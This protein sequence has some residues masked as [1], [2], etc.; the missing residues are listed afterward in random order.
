[1][2]RMANELYSGGEYLARN[3]TWHVEDSAWKAQQIL[4]MLQRH[5]L[6]PRTICE[7][8]CGAGEVLRQLQ[9]RMDP[10]CE[11]CGYD[12][13]PQAIALCRERANDR[14]RFHCRDFLQE[15]GA[16]FDLLLLIDLIEHL[17]DYN[18]FLR[19]VKPRSRYTILHIPLDLSVQ[20]K[21]RP[22]KLR[23]IRQVA[24]H[25][26]YF[27][28]ATALDG[29]RDAGYEIVDSFLTRGA[30]ESTHKQLRTRVCNSFRRLAGVF[31]EDLASRVLGGFSLLVLAT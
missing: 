16:S 25:L 3:P 4:R 10:S 1:M 31:G 13:S 26:H 22:G 17:E 28:R 8:G 9:S 6:T 21:L 18:S 23:A 29:L 19:A 15:A 27:T 12:I 14:L 2:T 30:L 7:V 20:A 24:G 5:S 11:F